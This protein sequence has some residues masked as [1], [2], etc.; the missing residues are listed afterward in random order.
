MYS[1]P[2]GYIGKNVGLQVYDNQI[3]VYYNT[4]LIVV[5]PVSNYMLN[6]KHEH[7]VETLSTH[8][9]YKDKI[10]ELALKNLAAMNEVHKNE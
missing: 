7:Y 1:I 9:P 8:L 5:H 6:F 4:D 2:P 3:Q 10:D